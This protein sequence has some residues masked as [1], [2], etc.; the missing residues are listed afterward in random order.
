[1]ILKRKPQL[2]HILEFQQGVGRISSPQGYEPRSFRRQKNC[3]IANMDWMVSSDEIRIQT[4]V[5]ALITRSL[6]RFCLL[7]KSVQSAAC[8]PTKTYYSYSWFKWHNMCRF[9]SAMHRRVKQAARA[10]VNQ[11]NNIRMRIRVKQSWTLWRGRVCQHQSTQKKVDNNCIEVGVQ[12][13]NISLNDM[14]MFGNILF[15]DKTLFV[16]RYALPG[17]PKTQ[18]DTTDADGTH[19]MLIT[20]KCI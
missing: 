2:D 9:K 6:E 17:A 5:W 3:Y 4:T 10:S 1:M 7:Y 19:Y 11:I 18:M 12:W 13:K 14:D 16:P 15:V 20:S 8:R